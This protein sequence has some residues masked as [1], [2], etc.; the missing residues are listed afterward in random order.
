MWRAAP[1]TPGP[2]RAHSK[3]SVRACGE[4]VILWRVSPPRGRPRLC[5]YSHL[6]EAGRAHRRARLHQVDDPVR[7]AEAA[8]PA[9]GR[10]SAARERST[11][12]R[13]ALCNVLCALR[14]L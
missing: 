4:C 8:L 9:R 13:C 12:H 3:V 1:L 5:D 14:E 7:E 10:E 6:L 2:G 11:V